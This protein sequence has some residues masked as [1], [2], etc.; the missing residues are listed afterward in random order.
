MCILISFSENL[1]NLYNS[2]C[3]NLNLQ[4]HLVALTIQCFATNPNTYPT[5]SCVQS[6]LKGKEFKVTDYNEQRPAGGAGLLI[7]NYIISNS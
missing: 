7:L 6:S 4:D 1:T 2:D 5:G 3:E